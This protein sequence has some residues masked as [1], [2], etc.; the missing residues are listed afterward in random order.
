MMSEGVPPAPQVLPMSPLRRAIAARMTAAKPGI[1]HY[2]VGASVNMEA[3]IA[4]RAAL[5]VEQGR[6][7]S[8]NAFIVKAAAYALAEMPDLNVQV[9]DR[10][11]H[12]FDQVDISVVVAVDGGL[13]TPV[14][15]NAGGKTIGEIGEEVRLL[16][17][18]ALDGQLRMDEIMGGT[19]SI[20]NLGMFGVESFDAIINAPQG[21]ILAVA[22]ALPQPVVDAAGRIVVARV[23]QMSLAVDHRA[24]DGALA[25]RFL[26]AL[27]ERL[28]QPQD[29][30][31]NE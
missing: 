28:E 12:R 6:A 20:S 19:F 27:R 5:T 17:A 4:L 2:R 23:M 9:A 14:V 16:T 3:L 22:S 30:G 29:W 10:E 24:I 8:V 1:P 15:R 31:R 25:A 7:P 26:R 18:R 13:A 21:A 11:I